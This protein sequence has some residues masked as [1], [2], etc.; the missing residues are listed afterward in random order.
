M[1]RRWLYYPSGGELMTSEYLEQYPPAPLSEG[2][3]KKIQQLEQQLSQEL[4]RPIIVMA[5]EKAQ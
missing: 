3:V 4:N 5:F 1:L 2:E